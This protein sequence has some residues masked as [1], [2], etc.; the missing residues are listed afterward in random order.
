[1]KKI[2]TYLLLLVIFFTSFNINAGAE[3]EEVTLLPAVEATNTGDKWGYI[4]QTGL[5]VIKPTYDF[6]ADFNDKGIAIVKNNTNSEFDYGDVYFINKSG[7]VVSGPFTSYT[8]VFI[9]GLAIIVTNK[10]SSVVVDEA[11]KVI[12][13]SKYP[14]DNYSESLLSFY[15]SSKNCYGFMD[16]KGKIVLPAKYYSVE[17][18]KNGKA[19]V[20]VNAGK[21]SV[22]D[23]NGKVLENLKSYNNYSSSEGL[24]VYYDEK[25][26]NYGY[27]LFNG[28]V[29][30]KPQFKS[31]EPF[32]DGYT[33]VS[34]PHGDY[35]Q[36]YGLINKKGEYVVKPEYSEVKYLGQGLYAVAKNFDLFS[37]YY[38]PKALMN[39]KGELLTDYQF[40][41]ISEFAGEY[42]IA[43]K[44]TTTLFIDR[45]GNIVEKLPQLK[46]IGH[47]E[48]IGDIIKAEVDGGLIYFDKNGKIIWQKN[49]TVLLSNNIIVNK[50]KYRRDY[51]TYIEYPEVKGMKDNSIQEN[52]NARLKKFFLDGY[53]GDPVEIMGNIDDN[54]EYYEDISIKYTLEKNND[55]LIIEKSGY[56]YPIGA[57]HGMPSKEYV[58][59]DTSTG[60][61]YQLKD[62]F[63]A[64][65]K[66]SEKLA[67]IVN[68]KFALN[69]RIGDISGEFSYFVDKVDVSADQPFILGKDSLKVY[70]YPYE[71]SS[72][73]AGF[74]EFEIPY[75]QLTSII[76][77]KGAFW[78]SF[79]KKIL[80]KK[81]NVISYGINADTVKSIES[82]MDFY[83]KNLIEAINSNNFSK[84][85][86][87]LLKGSNLYNSQ[88]KLVPYLYNKNTKE[89]LTKYEIYAIDYD[90]E[91]KQYRAYVLEEI[92]IKYS[93]K[94][95][96]NNKYSWCYTLKADSSGKLKLTDIRKW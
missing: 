80:T 33:V 95:Y 61:F 45:K 35:G 52:V 62:L 8:P 44:N 74:I 92:A 21:Y 75:G 36:R 19:I 48:F 7:K 57:A 51:L 26:S 41:S 28:T 58:Y 34:I 72:Y 37:E 60:V 39:I 25:S 12:L 89:K 30:I 49:D 2:I 66:Y 90:Y 43:N 81:I 31:A 56:W 38:A 91:N 76:D 47:M 9:N 46:G 82:V 18:F 5:F 88:K 14:L 69:K 10:A 6:A 79:D 68:N 93:G 63:K 85:E 22:I 77:T 17:P 71:I 40:N 1:M 73:A 13:Q 27:K 20:Q 15:D 11:G 50:L 94:N 86:G 87:C 55:L 42:A 67:S 54:D 4:N 59:I 65:S 84:V 16:L 78:N 83:E 64:N 53:E 29:S 24:T 23:K 70:Y 32:K 96:V 3:V